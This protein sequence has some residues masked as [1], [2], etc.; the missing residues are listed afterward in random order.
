MP[1]QREDVDLGEFENDRAINPDNL[2][3]EAVQQSEL[4]F[5][6]AER[7]A[8]ARAEMDRARLRL[9]EAESSGQLRCR[10]HPEEFGLTKT[11]EE[12]IKAAV[13]CS[14][15][16]TQHFDAWIRAKQ[17]SSLM[18][19]AV[20]AMEQKKRMIEVL[21]T[22]HGQKYFASPRAPRDLV[23]IYTKH[24]E[25]RQKDLA[26]R[27]RKFAVAPKKKRVKKRTKKKRVRKP[28]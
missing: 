10:K 4:F 11:T 3:V 13:R 23:A 2:D 9:D 16:Y 7:A 1:K 27:Q 20:E 14:D 15:N 8:H 6:W 21:V 22:L 19:R 24:R 28:E 5:K 17:I 18:D 26:A 25:D 12:A